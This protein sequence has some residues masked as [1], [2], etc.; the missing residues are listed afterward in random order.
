MPR[1][2]IELYIIAVCNY[3]I[4]KSY[5]IATI[6]SRNMEYQLHAIS[7]IKLAFPRLQDHC[8]EIS[9]ILLIPGTCLSSSSSPGGSPR[10]RIRT[11]TEGEQ[12]R[13]MTFSKVDYPVDIRS[14]SLLTHLLTKCDLIKISGNIAPALLPYMYN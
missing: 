10:T 8:A 9:C 1:H 7:F 14:R 12:N 5:N 2:E 3:K 11:R 6:L 13:E 4:P